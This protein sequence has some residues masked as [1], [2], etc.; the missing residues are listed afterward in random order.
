MV[1]R[2]SLE[3]KSGNLPSWED[4]VG[5]YRRPLIVWLT[6]RCRDPHLAEELVQ[7]FLVKM[8]TRDGS[9]GLVSPEKGK[10]RTWLLTSLKNH[11]GDHLRREK[12]PTEELPEGLV[13]EGGDKAESLYDLAWA[14]ALARRALELTRADYKGRGKG[15]LFDALPAAIDDPGADSNIGRASAL[16]IKAN[17]FAVALMRFREKIA[18]RLWDEVERTVDCDGA[19]VDDE[20]K[21]LITVLGRSGGLR[22]AFDKSPE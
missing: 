21:H 9:F 1:Q 22:S 18:A 11:W 3:Q 6:L 13:A 12:V 10:M 20:L 15:K 8:F 7:S 5:I 4:F 19:E 16:G 17:T 2:M 14:R